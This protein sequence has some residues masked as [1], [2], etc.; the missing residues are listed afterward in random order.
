ML[1]LF[2]V[3]PESVTLSCLKSPRAGYQTAGT[4]QLPQSLLK[5]FKP[6]DAKPAYSP[7]SSVPHKEPEAPVCV[8]LPLPPKLLLLW[9]GPLW[10][11]ETSPHGF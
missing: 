3:T 5:L 9:V 7:Q 10:C 6:S 1:F 8:S 4:T 11:D 2:P